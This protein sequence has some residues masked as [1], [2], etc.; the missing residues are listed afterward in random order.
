MAN[1]RDGPYGMALPRSLG[2]L[3]Y[4]L[5]GLLL[6]TVYSCGVVSPEIVTAAEF[7]IPFAEGWN[8]VSIPLEQ[9]NSTP[10]AVLASI[11]GNFTCIFAYNSSRTGAEWES[12]VPDR[13]AFLNT[14]ERIEPTR[15][16]WLYLATNDTLQLNGTVTA[17][18]TFELHRGW[19]LIGFP[20]LSAQLAG[21]ALQNVKDTFSIMYAYDP[22]GTVTGWKFYEPNNPSSTLLFL[23]PGF[24]YWVEATRN[25]TWTFNGTQFETPRPDVT[26]ASLISTPLVPTTQESVVLHLTLRNSGMMIDKN[27]TVMVWDTYGGNKTCLAALYWPDGIPADSTEASV[28][29][30]GNLAGGNHTIS[31]EVD[32]ENRI[33]EEDETNNEFIYNLY[34][35]S[36]LAASIQPSATTGEVPLEI[37]FSGTGSGGSAPYALVWDGGV[38]PYLKRGVNV[39]YIYSVPGSY[40]PYLAVT[41]ARRYSAGA[42]VNVTAQ[43]NSLAQQTDFAIAITDLTVASNRS[44]QINVTA[45]NQELVDVPAVRVTVRVYNSDA[46]AEFDEIFYDDLVSIQG[47]R[48]R[49]LIVIADNLQPGNYTARADINFYGAV[50]ESDWANYTNNAD[51]QDF[52]F[53]GLGY[54]PPISID[55]FTITPTEPVVNAMAAATVNVSNHGL[56]YRLVRGNFYYINTAGAKEFIGSSRIEKIEVGESVEL[57]RI[58][59]VPLRETTTVYVDI[60]DVLM[61]ATRVA[62][63]EQGVTITPYDFSVT[64]LSISPATNATDAIPLEVTA[65]INNLCNVSG[66]VNYSLYVDGLS[67]LVGPIT[68]YNV[69]GNGSTNVTFSLGWSRNDSFVFRS[70]EYHLPKPIVGNH[71]VV[72][73]LESVQQGTLWSALF[74]ADPNNNVVGDSI[75]VLKGPDCRVQHL[76]FEPYPVLNENSTITL[77]LSN[78]GQVADTFNVTV[79]NEYFRWNDSQYMITPIGNA[80]VYLAPNESATIAFS[81]T[82]SQ[83]NWQLVEVDC[84]SNWYSKEVSVRPQVRITGTGWYFDKE[85]SSEN[86]ADAH[87]DYDYVFAEN[88]LKLWALANAWEGKAESQ[89]KGAVYKE[90]VVDDGTTGN[91]S[92]G[93]YIVAEVG[94]AGIIDTLTYGAYTDTDYG[95]LVI[96][97]IINAT[98]N[99]WKDGEVIYAAASDNSIFYKRM[100]ILLDTVSLFG[101]EELIVVD[102]AKFGADFEDCAGFAYFNGTLRIP[103]GAL[104]PPLEF[105]NGEEYRVYIYFESVVDA[106]GS[107]I[108]SC[109][110]YTDFYNREPYECADSSDLPRRGIWL[111]NPKMVVKYRRFG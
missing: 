2:R 42:T 52:I 88:R 100:G 21:S 35:L 108:G 17:S 79:D 19:N 12:Y 59:R 66:N 68:A 26:P 82:P 48:T 105:R 58:F 65:Q 87:Y 49:D 71:T 40:T 6:V 89:P 15:G 51:L 16:F 11:M 77:K 43:A 28:I 98:S 36:P 94:Y 107:P 95:V 33:H 106:D 91:D 18:A 55:H 53:T 23:E 83:S 92:Y 1:Q 81:W 111:D 20:A 69:P 39:S 32:P 25:V 37:E 46:P 29:V 67:T 109:H 80:S 30:L 70:T 72:M 3:R 104:K 63:A 74:E 54:Q 10:A 4:L 8:L 96:V 14:V 31:A 56:Y 78:A 90:I 93:G 7:D 103:A 57:L 22:R 47:A 41:D 9:P 62:S 101:P 50:P 44:V 85:T 75:T 84:G 97:G 24:G 102:I 60:V 34:V 86:I 61:N 76:E 27:V 110:A 99:S 73:L 38:P 5:L 45:S 13:P 64:N